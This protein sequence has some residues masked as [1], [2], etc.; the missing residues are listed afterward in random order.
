M[1]KTVL[2]AAVAVLLTG[3][4]Y[5]TES[6]IVS[7]GWADAPFLARFRGN[8]KRVEPK[9]YCY[10]TLGQVDCYAKPLL[11]ENDRLASDNTPI[12]KSEAV[13]PAVRSAARLA[14][15]PVP[16]LRRIP[17]IRRVDDRERIPAVVI[18]PAHAKA[19]KVKAPACRAKAGTAARRGRAPSRTVT[20][21][22]C[23]ASKRAA[24]R[25]HMRKFAGPTRFR[26]PGRKPALTTTPTT[27]PGLPRRLVQARV[28]N[29]A[30]DAATR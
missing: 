8:T 26:T 17:A 19:A 30:S 7:S 16:V 10:R 21:R 12:Q 3:C 25:R 6:G 24:R 28:A 22:A 5:P 20:G 13:A 27:K 15:R 11:G 1:M 14:V 9:I 2:L 29:P 23:A 4:F 18:A